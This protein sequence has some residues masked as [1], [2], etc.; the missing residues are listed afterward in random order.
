MKVYHEERKR[1]CGGLTRRADPIICLVIESQSSID[2]GNQR[3]FPAGSFI[4]GIASRTS[5]APPKD[6]QPHENEIGL[7]SLATAMLLAFSVE[8]TVTRE[9]FS[10]VP[11]T[12]GRRQ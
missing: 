5:M 12:D 8:E 9:N 4:L 6:S 1:A 3:G 11:A 7:C 2:E 10:A